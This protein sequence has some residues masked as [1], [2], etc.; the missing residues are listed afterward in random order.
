MIR[1]LRTSHRV[2]T[3]ALAIV[4]IILFIAAIAARKP[5]PMTPR[6]PEKLTQ[7]GGGAR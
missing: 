2:M 7:A 5:A 1:R 4:L 3:A 6:I